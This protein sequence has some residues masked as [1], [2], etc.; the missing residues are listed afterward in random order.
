MKFEFAQFVKVKT[1][2]IKWDI[3]WMMEDDGPE[4]TKVLNEANQTLTNYAII[5]LERHDPDM[6]YKVAESL[7][8]LGAADTEPLWQF[9]DL[10]SQCYGE[11][12]Y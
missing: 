9:R 4:Y 6:F 10:W 11:D 12:I 7:A 3:Y 8:S 2:D 1:L 5:A